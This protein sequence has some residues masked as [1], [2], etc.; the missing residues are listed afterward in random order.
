MSKARRKPGRK[1]VAAAERRSRMVHV[2]VNAA[3]MKAMQKAAG[4][5]YLAVWAR[6]ALMELTE[7]PSPVNVKR[8][9][10]KK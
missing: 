1:P 5:E 9:K 3:E 7:D 2:P 4:S 10:P 6:R 8:E